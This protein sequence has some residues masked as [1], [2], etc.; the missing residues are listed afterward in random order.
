MIIKKILWTI[1]L[2]IIGS[3]ML[4]TV[5]SHSSISSAMVATEQLP[6]LPDSLSN[7]DAV[8]VAWKSRYRMGL[9]S[10]GKLEKIYVIGLG[11]KPLGH[12]QMQGDNRTPEGEYRI[13]QKSRGPFSG[14][15]AQFLGVG[16]LRINYPNNTDAVNGFQKGLITEQQKNDIIAAEKSGKE[17]PKNTKLGGGIGIHGWWGEWPGKDRQNLTWGCISVQNSQ[18][19]ELYRHVNV[20]TKLVIYP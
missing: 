17:P 3:G 15:Y 2:L 18:L 11:K 16:W 14:P 9:Y 10:K 5:Q 19:D 8:L 12:K 6:P 4:W 20:G 13:T 7:E 1:V